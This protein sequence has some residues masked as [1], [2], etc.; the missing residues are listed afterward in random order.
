MS[1]NHNQ[2]STLDCSNI[3]YKFYV[4]FC[5]YVQKELSW[6]WNLRFNGKRHKYEQCK[7]GK[8]KPDAV[9]IA[10]I[11]V[12]LALA[13][14][15]LNETFPKLGISIWFENLLTW[16]VQNWKSVSCGFLLILLGL[17]GKSYWAGAWSMQ[18][19]YLRTG[20]LLHEDTLDASYVPK[21]VPRELEAALTRES[22]PMCWGYA[23]RLYCE[24]ALWDAHEKGKLRITESNINAFANNRYSEKWIP[25]ESE[26][27]I[28]YIPHKQ[29]W[30][31]QA[32]YNNRNH[33]CGGNSGHK[34]EIERFLKQ[35]AHDFCQQYVQST[36]G[37][38]SGQQVWKADPRKLQYFRETW[39]AR[40]SQLGN[41]SEIKTQK[42]DFMEIV[43]AEMQDANENANR[44]LTKR[45]KQQKVLYWLT[46]GT[47]ICSAFAGAIGTIFSE[48]IKPE[49]SWVS[50]VQGA[51]LF[52][53]MLGAGGTAVQVNAQDSMKE[54]EETWLRQKIYYAKLQCETQRFCDSL[55]PYTE[56]DDEKNFKIYIEEIEKLRKKDW[57]NFFLNMNCIND[58]TV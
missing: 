31:Y 4:V 33:C 56:S 8:R 24:K 52:L 35:T 30:N 19:A 18:D 14:I 21:G 2:T 13:A 39:D 6:K 29:F 58:F 53:T 3:P 23:M 40:I 22:N 55:A 42:K 17:R 20:L 12:I 9:T 37:I 5:Q 51:F 32:L 41:S 1:N 28:S 50:F 26:N 48:G 46:I 38:R 45:N 34:A 25:L 44:H 10:L 36:G 7:L 57:E 27:F 15:L 54:A 16:L 49:F 11:I 43:I 47:A